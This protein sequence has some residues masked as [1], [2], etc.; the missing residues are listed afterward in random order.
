MKLS[1]NI[2]LPVTVIT[3]KVKK[4]KKGKKKSES[5]EVIS[6]TKE[7][8]VEVNINSEETLTQL[9]ESLSV[10]PK[11]ENF[12]NYSIFFK[13]T[14][15]SK[16]DEFTTFGEIFD[17]L[18]V[19]LEKP[20]SLKLQEKGYKLSDIYYH[21]NKFRQVI[22]LHF[23]DKRSNLLGVNAGVAKFDDLKI[24]EESDLSKCVD[25]INDSNYD[26]EQL[27]KLNDPYSHYVSPV[28]IS[29]SPWNPVPLIR[30]TAGDL[31]YLTI[32]TL[33]HE[34][35][36]V[37]CHASGFYVN[38]C[39]NIKF[40]PAPKSQIYHLLFD[41]VRNLSPVFEA[42]LAKNT[43]VFPSV[44]DHPESYLLPS[45]TA[46]PW[47]TNEPTKVPESSFPILP[48]LQNG[49]D[50]ADFVKDWNEEFQSIR[51]LPKLNI[52]ERILR[53]KL[54][55][56]IIT[57]FNNVATKTAIE[58][59]NGSIPPMNYSEDANQLTYLRNGIFYWHAIDNGSFTE[60][61]GDEAARYAASKDLN[62]VR[63]INRLDLS[64]GCL[65]TCVVDY[66]GKRIVCQAP[67]PGIFNEVVGE[68]QGESADNGEIEGE[69]ES[70]ID[71]EANEK[72]AYGIN[73][74]GTKIN[75]DKEFIG[76]LTNLADI[77][78]LK[79]HTVTI[80]D[81]DVELVTS[82][83]IKG[84]KGTDG[85]KYVIDL[86]RTSAMDVNFL[87]K[88]Y[89]HKEPLIRHEAVEEWWKRKIANYLKLEA[90]KLENEKKSTEEKEQILI[91]SN[92]VT[93]NPDTF[94][95]FSESDIDQK[96][97]KELGD[98]I[99]ILVDEFLGDISKNISP[100]DGKHLSTLMHRHGINMRYLGHVTRRCLE[101]K[102]QEI[103]KLETTIKENQVLAEE[104]S[105]AENTEKKDE[106]KDD[107][108]K[109]E[110]EE[111]PSKGVFL[112]IIANFESIHKIAINEMVSRAA[113]H[114]LRKS[115]ETIDPVMM[116]Y[117]VAHFFNCLLAD[118]SVDI[119]ANLQALYSSEFTKL[120]AEEVKSM[121]VS[122]IKSR[123][124][125]DYEW[126]ELNKT[127]IMREISLKFGIQWKSKTFD[128]FSGEDIIN[129]VPVVKD[130]TYKAS[131][132][133]E[134]S[135]TAQRELSSVEIKD[136]DSEE[137]KKQKEEKKSDAIVL[138]NELLSFYEQIY[139]RVHPETT[140]YCGFLSQLYSELN[141][142]SNLSHTACILSERSFGVD[143]YN[144]ITSYVNAGYFETNDL[145]KSIKLYNQAINIW[146]II[147]GKDHPSLINTY[148]N[149]AENL[150]V[151][152]H[153]SEGFKLFEKSIELCEQI[154]G[155]CDITA[156]IYFRYGSS[157]I[158]NSNFKAAKGKFE[159]AY[160]IFLK[161][162]GPN[163]QFTKKSLN[164]KTNLATY[165]EYQKNDKK[166]VN[167]PVPAPSTK[168]KKKKNGKKAVKI[169][170]EIANQSVDDILAFIEGK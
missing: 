98:F 14:D 157:L 129:F 22:G 38:S 135:D 161:V 77:F 10:I 58:I 154:C 107:E 163:D 139:G 166:L 94:T 152:K 141:I 67:I 32:S 136:E 169:N 112:P 84:I 97:V 69:K 57:D 93:I 31:L 170:E 123:F 134:I 143:S 45:N 37:T 21:I 165:L 36:T 6:T 75:N 115:S 24:N 149:L 104:L 33:E 120:T 153:F 142:E 16:F 72:V 147:Y 150:T 41:L 90:E 114:I 49:V 66:L 19:D 158:N 131:I 87:N 46:Y 61:G 105:K 110:K 43:A 133:D 117:F 132:L 51:E 4:V 109:D 52:N 146:G 53:E 2:T 30:K 55:I 148:A 88:D 42:A 15:L 1:L 25:A 27:G 48:I 5:P 119:P 26:I 155:D 83:D 125:Y 99:H 116:P 56:K 108:K 17:Q 128:T 54:L 137:E 7:D 102:Q 164:F 162:L 40:N 78:H 127:V 50:G 144:T 44:Y 11:S 35:F 70:N 71:E 82:K 91:Q 140:S 121:I 9:R 92:T 65:V 64:I 68:L 13:E 160:D 101:M 62:A 118:G 89:I 113:K 124:D 156:L 34:T 95:G 103:E 145:S 3:E 100:F 106:K 28:K 151:A 122:E 81:E 63:I 159:R 138:F 47:I 12:T 60:R 23:L 168:N 126:S 74:S 79:P 80:N 20:I 85:R 167:K 39:S 130:S 76:P 86:F 59:V 29:L 73:T 8:L 18:G 111:E 96:E